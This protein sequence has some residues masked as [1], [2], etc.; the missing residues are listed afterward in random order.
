MTIPTL[1]QLSEIRDGL[2]ALPLF[3]KLGKLNGSM[4]PD[5]LVDFALKCPAISPVQ[6]RS[7]LVEYARIVAELRPRAVLEIGTFRGGTLFIHSRLAT[8]DATLIS[9]DLPGSLLGIL[10]MGAYADFQ[11]FHSKWADTPPSPSGFPSQRNIFSGFRVCKGP[12]I[13][14]SI[15]GWGS[16]LYGGS[17]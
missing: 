10:A 14:S 8:P 16:F 7:E 9:V 12:T 5:K 17:C 15:C 2:S 13:G 4:T 6:M 3:L 11:S 1:R